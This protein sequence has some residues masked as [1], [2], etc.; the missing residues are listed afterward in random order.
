MFNVRGACHWDGNPTSKP[1]DS[2]LRRCRQS[3]QSQANDCISLTT[4][5]TLESSMLK[6]PSVH[7]ILSQDL[8]LYIWSHHCSHK[9]RIATLRSLRFIMAKISRHSLAFNSVLLQAPN[10]CLFSRPSR[11]STQMKLFI[12]RPSDARHI[13]TVI[14]WL[15]IYSPITRVAYTTNACWI[16]RVMSALSYNYRSSHN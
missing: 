6:T 3:R 11:K 13:S 1:S 10:Y 5:A 16:E 8:R 15:L 12:W 4:T 7:R 9:T 14:I 2:S